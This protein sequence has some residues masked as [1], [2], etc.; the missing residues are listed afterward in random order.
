MPPAQHGTGGTQVTPGFFT[1]MDIFNFLLW[2]RGIHYPFFAA[3]LPVLRGLLW[4][5]SALPS[6]AAPQP[7]PVPTFLVLLPIPEPLPCPGVGCGPSACS[8]VYPSI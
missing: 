6:S 3:D 4:V 1:L 7:F 8:P 2:T 5:F